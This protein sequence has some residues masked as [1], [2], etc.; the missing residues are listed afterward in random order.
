MSKSDCIKIFNAMIRG[1]PVSFDKLISIYSD[2][3]TENNVENSDKLINL[4]MQNPQLM[5]Q[6]IPKI[7]DYYCKKY[8]ILSVQQAV[9]N[10]LF[11]NLKPILYYE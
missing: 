9:D 10:S 11:N 8:T 1:T 7:V 6:A 3:L 4:V 2:Y 5:Q